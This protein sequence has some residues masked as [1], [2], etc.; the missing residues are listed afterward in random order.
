ME[1]EKTSN[2]GPSRTKGRT[3]AR[4]GSFGCSDDDDEDD[5]ENEEHIVPMKLD[6][7]KKSA[8]TKVQ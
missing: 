5:S 7:S 3:S 1:L 4:T 6:F 8:P 2:G